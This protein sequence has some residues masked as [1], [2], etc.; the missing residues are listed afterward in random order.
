MSSTSITLPSGVQYEQP[1]GLFIGNEFVEASGDT[2]EVLDPRLGILDD[3]SIYYLT[4]LPQH[5]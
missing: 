1:I 4:F 5:G 2:F 3:S